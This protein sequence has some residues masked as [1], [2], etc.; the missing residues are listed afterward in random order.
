LSRPVIFTVSAI[1]DPEASV[2]SGH[3]D[4]IPA[5]ADAPTLDELM[6]KISRIA[7]DLAPLNHPELAPEDI[8]VQIAAMRDGVSSA[9]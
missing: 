2:W 7:L 4:E 5:A 6:E 1:W 3:C 8:F 9:A